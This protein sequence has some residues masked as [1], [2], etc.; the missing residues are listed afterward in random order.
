MRHGSPHNRGKRPHMRQVSRLRVDDPLP[1]DQAQTVQTLC[2]GRLIKHAKQAE[3]N[4]TITRPGLRKMERRLE[5]SKHTKTGL[6][7]TLETPNLGPPSIHA[8]Q[9]SRREEDLNAL[10]DQVSVH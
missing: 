2:E 1:R 8:R 9:S 10:R 3:I 5:T 7:I 4:P 6:D